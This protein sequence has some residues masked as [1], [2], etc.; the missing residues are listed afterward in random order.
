[1]LKSFGEYKMRTNEL[2]VTIRESADQVEYEQ[3]MAVSNNVL[4][5]E[6][7]AR[8]ALTARGNEVIDHKLIEWGRWQFDS[9]LEEE[10]DAEGFS[11]PSSEA[12]RKAYLLVKQMRKEEWDLPTGII[13]DGE[14]GIVFEN[15]RDST[16]Q[17]IEIDHKG[18]MCLVT[19][20]NCVLESR[21]PVDVE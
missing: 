18:A 7:E 5:S 10:F 17:R 9:K 11:G 2:G 1:M 13:P 8:E 15:R 3:A 19:F 4:A 14:G 12:I 20:Q 21:V 16:Y 6:T